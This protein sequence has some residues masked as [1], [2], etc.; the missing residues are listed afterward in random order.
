MISEATFMGGPADGEVRAFPGDE[1]P[2]RVVFATINR[3]GPTSWEDGKFTY[4]R[5]VSQLDEGSL[6]VYVPA[7]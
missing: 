4:V 5:Q 1:P 2:L 6:W 7:P 3:T